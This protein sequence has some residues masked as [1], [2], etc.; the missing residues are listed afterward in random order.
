MN[1]A[2]EISVKGLVQGVG[3]RF[4]TK[5]KA[6][7]LGLVGDVENQSDGT[8]LIHVHGSI[9]P[10]QLFLEWCHDGPR[11]AEVESLSYKEIDFK[12]LSQFLILR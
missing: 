11:S 7:E 3:F 8:V 4:F 10:V 9:E 12:T 6:D 2:Y 1:K 5:K